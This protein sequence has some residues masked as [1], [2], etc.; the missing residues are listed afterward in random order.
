M[1]AAFQYEEI[2]KPIEGMPEIVEALS[3]NP[4]VTLTI[5]SDSISAVVPPMLKK[6]KE[7][8][9]QI[10]DILI[11][12]EIG[13]SKRDPNGGAFSYVLEHLGIN[14]PRTAVFIDDKQTYTTNARSSF[15]LR[16]LTFRGN[17]YRNISPVD[18][19]R[20]ELAQADLI[21]L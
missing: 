14:D 17:P 7:Y 1:L 13:A 3:Q 16:A 19:I 6:V 12:A 11:S 20:Q 5:L 10:D 9:P 18:R 2:H 21:K 8:Y 4:N 15:G